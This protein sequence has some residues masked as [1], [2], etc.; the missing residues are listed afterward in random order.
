MA[1]D[2]LKA[3]APHQSLDPDPDHGQFYDHGRELVGVLIALD[4]LAVTMAGQVSHYGDQRLLCDDAGAH[5]EHRLAA[6]RGQLAELD[7]AL[8]TATGTPTFQRR[9]ASA[10]SLERAALAVRPARRGDVGLARRPVRVRLSGGTRAVPRSIRRRARGFPD[11]INGRSAEAIP[12]GLWAAGTYDWPRSTCDE[13]KEVS[14][15]ATNSL[16]R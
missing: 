7:T 4:D 8:N 2:A 1:R 3:A 16:A 13:G 10:D 14:V 9:A 11:G 12:G 6:A 15:T 5:P